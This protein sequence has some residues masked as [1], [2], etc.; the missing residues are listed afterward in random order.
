MPD[1]APL[2]DALA[3]SVQAGYLGTAPEAAIAHSQHFIALLGSAERVLDLGSGGGVPGLVIAYRCPQVSVVLLDNRRQRTDLLERLVRRLQLSDRV[4]VC[5]GEAGLAG[6]A[7]AL[8]GQFDV[9]TARSF[10]P[11]WSV[12]ECAA[13][14]LAVGGRVLVSE[15][16]DRAE[17]WPTDG[18][19]LV[20]LEFTGTSA[21]GITTLRQT[22]ACPADWPRRSPTTPL[23]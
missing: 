21:E 8:R 15:P 16:P 13:P 3:L 12:A 9:V 11:P 6:R 19:A 22:S 2:L 7:P 18:L 14:F 23:F 20:G 4:V 5:S 1:D 17:R 10:G